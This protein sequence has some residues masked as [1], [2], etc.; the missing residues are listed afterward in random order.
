MYISW[1]ANWISL[2]CYYH[3]AYYVALVVA[4]TALLHNVAVCIYIKSHLTYLLT[5]F[6]FSWHNSPSGP[7]SAQCRGFTITLR[8]TTLDK[9]SLD[10]WPDRRRDLYLKTHASHKRQT[11]LHAPRG[12]RTRN[13][14]KGAPT[15]RCLRPRGHWI[16]DL[17]L[18]AEVYSLSFCTL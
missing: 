8:R 15:D 6:L 11:D 13:P 18:L 3:P 16:T 7:G 12:F 1:C 2:K 17:W 9:I 4:R 5:F 14:S 10:E